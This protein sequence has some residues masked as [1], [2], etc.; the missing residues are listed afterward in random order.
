MNYLLARKANS[1]L[2]DKEFQG[3]NNR[4]LS[5][6]EQI[7]QVK[8]ITLFE[9]SNYQID[10]HNFVSSIQLRGGGCFGST[11]N[12]S[13]FKSN[14]QQIDY[15]FL[16][17]LSTFA[18]VISEKSLSFQ[19]KLYQDE[20]LAAFQWFQNN[21]EQF[22][23]LCND[24]TE[25]TKNYQL[26][27]KIT[28]Q[29]M[30]QLIIYIKVSG[31]LFKQLL[32]IC[33]DFWKI[34]FSHQ[35]QN[36]DRYMQDEM[37]KSFLEIIEEVDSQ[38]SVE[39][40][41]IWI[42][43]A[44]FELQLIKICV[45]HCRT[46]SEKGKELVISI[47]SGLF[48]SI[49]QLKP[50]EELID[51]LIEGGK[52]LLLNFYDKQIQNPLQVYEI[53][54]YFEN[55]KWSIVFQLKLGYSIQN[56][57]KQIQDGYT[58][59]IKLSKDW[60]V[61][62]FW[63]NLISDIMCYRPIFLKTEIQQLQQSQTVDEETW[64]QLIIKLPYNKFAGKLKL[65]S[66][67]NFTLKQYTTLKLFQEY[68]IQNQC[69]IQLLPNYINF[70]FNAQERKQFQDEELFIQ[71][72]TN[73]SNL[74]ILKALMKQLRY[75]NDQVTSNFVIAKEKV[76]QH[77]T[78]LGSE[79]HIQ[80]KI[81]CQ[82]L[83]FLMKQIKQS[84][85][86]LLYLINEINLFVNKELQINLIIQTIFQEQFKILE[87]SKKIKEQ[88]LKD[89]Q[90]IENKYASEFLG[91]FQN[92]SQFW[93]QIAQYTSFSHIEL[94]EGN[95]ELEKS[96]QQQLDSNVKYFTNI[97]NFLDKFQL[98]ISNVKT[99]FL[100][101]LEQQKLK[102]LMKDSISQRK[103]LDIMIKLFNPKLTLK[104]INESIQYYQ[105]LLQEE[106]QIENVKDVRK[107]LIVIQSN[108]NIY[109]GLQMI[110]KQHQKKLL[111]IQKQFQGAFEKISVDHIK[112]Q[113]NYEI[114][115]KFHRTAFILEMGDQ[116]QLLFKKYQNQELTEEQLT[117]FNV[118]SNKIS[119]EIN[120]IK[121]M[122]W[123][124]QIKSHHILLLS[125]IKL[126]L[127]LLSFVQQDR[128]II[129]M[130]ISKLLDGYLKEIN[131]ED[132]PKEHLPLTKNIKQSST[133]D[134]FLILK[135]KDFFDCE[136]PLNIL[137]KLITK[138]KKIK[139]IFRQNHLN[140]ASQNL[141][142]NFDLLNK[143]K[144]T[145][146]LSLK[147]AITDLQQQTLVFCQMIDKHE[148]IT[149]V[150]EFIE[151][152]QN[153]PN[154]DQISALLHI[155]N[156]D[157]LN[158]Q[159][160]RME[161]GVGKV[162]IIQTMIA[163]L[164]K[165]MKIVQE[166]NIFDTISD[167]SY[168]VREL[169][170]FNLIKIQ[171]IIQEQPI[172]EFCENLLK[173]I[174]IIE[175]N[176]NVR[177]LLKNEEMIKM[178]KKLFSQDL[179]NF[180]L[181][182]KKE[183]QTKFKQIE[184]LET[185][186]LLSGNQ[187][188]IKKS[189]QE[190]Y[191]EFEIYLD[192][193]TDMSQ[194]LDISLVFLREISKDLKNIKSSIDQIFL[195]VKG[196]ED[197][198][199]R[200]RGKNFMELL[201]IRKQKVLYQKLENEQDQIH[202]EIKTQE[203]DPISGNKK[204]NKSGEFE[205]FLMKL[206]F[207]NYDGE[208]NEFLWSEY[209]SLKDVML[210][211]GKAGS[212]KSR[213]SRNIEEFI[214]ICDSI[215]P[216]WIPIYMSLPQLKDPNHNLIEQAL[217]SENYNFDNIQIRE[218]KDAVINGTL[219]IVIILESYDEMKYEY[220]GTN[221]YN[222]NRIANDL[223]LQGQDQKVKFIITTREEILNT[224]GYQ[225]WF[226]GSSLQNLKEI[227]ILPFRQEQ[228]SQYLNIYAEISIKRTIKRFYEFLK[229]LK[230]QKFQLEEF[231]LIWSQIESTINSIILQRRKSDMLFL[232]SDIERIIKAI[233]NVQFFSF[234]QSNQ[235][236]S[237]KKE[238][239][240]LW[241]EQK[242]QSVVKNVNITHLL[243]TPFMME[244]IVYVLPKMSSL[245]SKANRIREL[246]KKNYMI[247]K[248]EANNS[249]VQME[250][251]QKYSNNSINFEA[252]NYRKS[253]MMKEIEI[254][255]Q[256][257][258]ILEDL[259]NSNFFESFSIAD[260]L[261]C[262][263][264]TT[265]F[266]NR[267][268][269]VKFDANYVVSAFKLQQYT[270]FDFYEIFVNFYHNQQLQKLKDLGISVKEESMLQDLNDF[271][272]FL[273]IDMSLRQLTQVNYKQKRKLY[274]SSVKE[275][276][277][278]EVSWDDSYF[279]ENQDDFEYK[280]LL[281]KCM[282]INSKGSLYAFNHKSIQEFFVANYIINLIETIFSQGNGEA[283]QKFLKQ[284][285]FCK[286][287]FNLSLEHYSG[288][289][290][291]LK[292][293]I[294]QI[295]DIKNKLIQLTLLSRKNPENTLIRSA[296]NSIYILC[297]LREHFENI[298]LSDLF[299]YYTKLDGMSFYKCNL[300]NSSFN[301]VSIDSCNFNCSTIENAKWENLICKEK[302][303]IIAHP[304]SIKYV[305]FSDNGKFLISGSE[306][307]VIIKQE[308]LADS[309]PKRTIL[310]NTD[311]DKL[312]TISIGKNLLA[313]LSN[314]FLYIFSL[315]DLKELQSYLATSIYF[316]DADI[317]RFSPNDKYL[318]VTLRKGITL[319][320]LVE[321]L[322]QQQE[323]Q[324]KYLS[325]I[326][327][328]IIYHIAI[329]P[330]YQLLATG[331]YRVKIWN[332]SNFSDVQ[333]ILELPGET[334]KINA[335][336]FSKD[337]QVLAAAIGNK[338]EFW[339]IQ[340]LNQ[341]FLKYKFD[342]LVELEQIS[343]SNNGK[344]F[345]FRSKQVLKLYE[346]Q[347]LP[348]Q[349][350]FFRINSELPVDLIEISS[351]CQILAMSHIYNSQN[352]SPKITIWNVKNLHQM[353]MISV[354]KEQSKNISAL[355]IRNDNL[356]LGSGSLDHSICL[357]DLLKLVL[358]VKLTSHQD[359]ILDLAFSSNKQQM[360][361]CSVDATIIVW[362]TTNL[363]KPQ[364]KMTQ[365]QQ[366]GVKKVLYC[367]N[368]P[369]LV[370]M[371][372]QTD[373]EIKL[374]NSAEFKLIS[375]NTIQA[376]FIDINFSEDGENMISLNQDKILRIWKINE[377]GF[378]IYKQIKIDGEKNVNQAY[379]FD[380]QSIIARFG[381]SVYHLYIKDQEIQKK[382]KYGFSRKLNCIQVSQNK[383]IIVMKDDGNR[384]QNNIEI[385]VIENHNRQNN[386]QVEDEIN[387]FQFSND[388]SLL[389]VATEKG[390]F[391]KD[392]I[393]NQILQNFQQN[394]CCKLI[395]FIGKEQLAIMLNQ[396]LVLYDIQD[397]N[398]SKII[399]IIQLYDTP[400]KMIFLEQRQEIC[401]CSKTSVVLIS[402]LEVQQ[403]KLIQ[404][405]EDIQ[406]MAVI[407]D[408][409]Q[410]FMGIGKRYKMQFMSLSNA[411]KIEKTSNLYKNNQNKPHIYTNFSQDCNIF[412]ILT[413]ELLYLQLDISSNQ[414]LKKVSFQPYNNPCALNNQETLIIVN[415][416]GINQKNLFLIDLETQKTVNCFDDIDERKSRCLTIVFSQDGQ[417]FLTS[418][419]NLTIKFWD[420]KS[421]KLLS[422]FKT[423]T[424]S[425][426]LLTISIKGI[427]AQTSD[428]IIKLWDL[429]ALKQQQQE[430]DGHNSSVSEIC[431]S[432]DG[433]Q[434]VTGSEEE[435]IRWDFI[436]LKQLDI[437][438][439][440]K[441]PISKF[442]FSPNSQYF[443]ALFEKSIHIWK[444]ITRYII[445]FHKTY[446]CSLQEQ[447]LGVSQN[448]VIYKNGE[449]KIFIMNF[450]QISKQIQI[451]L[452]SDLRNQTRKIILSPN[453]LIKT[454]P[455][456]ILRINNKLELKKE[457]I[458]GISASQI[459][460]IAYCANTQRFAFE[461]ED[462]SIIIWSIE[463]KQ[464]LGILNSNENKNTQ[465]VCM[466]FSGNSK[467]LF[468]YHDDKKIRLWN[469]TDKYELIQIQ[470][471]KNDMYLVY[472][473]NLQLHSSKDEEYILIWCETQP[474]GDFQMGQICFQIG[475]VVRKLDELS[476]EW[477]K[478]F[479]AAFNLSNNV[480][481]L[482]TESI[483]KLYDISQEEIRIIANLENN[484]LDD[485]LCQSNLMFSS[486]GKILLS[487]GTDFTVRLCDISDQSSIIVK[488]NMKKPIQAVAVQFLNSE[489]IR[490]Y[491]ESGIIIDQNISEY[492]EIGVIK[493]EQ[494]YDFKTA[495]QQ[496]GISK[497]SGKINN[498]TLE[499][500]DSQ[501][502]QLQF[503]LNKFSSKISAI[504]FTPSQEQFI[505]GMEDGSIL[506]YKIDQQTIKIYDIPTCYHIFAKNPLLS[507]QNCN[508]R[509]STF[510][511]I[512]NE[513]FEKVLCE[514]GAIK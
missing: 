387:D 503:T 294:I 486:D 432:P 93:L 427:L 72:L 165:D 9:I 77:D 284:C 134:E 308:M 51:S 449:S 430:M 234:I 420:T 447:K 472:S 126:Q 471:L 440:G 489:T 164:Q 412:S 435:I 254:T 264:N 113:E 347:K 81:F 224:I 123:P 124:D 277:N 441:S 322:L 94:I 281:R 65:F 494:Q 168:K 442:C 152:S 275:E 132:K 332:S 144:D 5:I 249:Q 418:Y 431:I 349:Q 30:R 414:I 309:E 223:N 292:P 269:N 474:W 360:A 495:K 166:E 310:T 112:T 150:Y 82:E 461:D 49:S 229:Q 497:Y 348:D 75:Q 350:D 400:E 6:T 177:S 120:K 423:D 46:N 413:S 205:T 513:N 212:G 478:K 320:F 251:Y 389:A 407:F 245:F 300:S 63:V 7:Q 287:E 221:L 253:R 334:M 105:K 149:F 64:N 262:V 297:S 304:S 439:K 87:D 386:V 378:E 259:D 256:F 357:W 54:L 344:L 266:S 114:D 488:V 396:Q 318:A 62:Y 188:E 483:L 45:S 8:N 260:S 510:K 401:I 458:A 107:I 286:N 355:K 40:V 70:N 140:A 313:C 341:V 358:I 361:S 27:E 84:S 127:E 246:L 374:W 500:F 338:L 36:E 12:R 367:P 492:L 346:V 215:S 170:V 66:N 169:V 395:C 265:I 194:R 137:E 133:D 68:L 116:L 108:I 43:G 406:P 329:S 230:G 512:E 130:E 138:T 509:Q 78:L 156:F 330:N 28:E 327:N 382:H 268:F 278:V 228:S 501:T 372:G 411:I 321:N 236:L 41:N 211:K 317:I 147:Q 129:Q 402:L 173:Q 502:S 456:E 428:N 244:I 155:F 240:Q 270:A 312:R 289:L 3:Q 336:A 419:S 480:I 394:C 468:S 305:T 409:E 261:E 504:Q 352:D 14:L 383:K 13:D 61:H 225:T 416:P 185:Q 408:S 227:E 507:A 99:K 220:I 174:W 452:Q 16:A 487:L 475:T 203:Y 316:K 433:L 201:N 135:L 476:G 405:D 91:N 448:H 282:L 184:Q 377:Q 464:Q 237:L 459:T 79:K 399:S 100:K 10:Y 88:I 180:S 71:S 217:E 257:T 141:Q 345:A 143:L 434:M 89:I 379:F 199:R 252:E 235:M 111:S 443:V 303:S 370:S 248:K 1:I 104:L 103:L 498:R 279:D 67:N 242:F 314:K 359:K 183:M 371:Q 60:R 426:Q 351:D 34:I 131:S 445:E 153:Q 465:L 69:D 438:I 198:I 404:F 384:N 271:S 214:W 117:D 142:N 182:I 241:G 291:L 119:K 368:R 296:S 238:L 178:Q 499:I 57:I 115:I 145:Q 290:E 213:A 463:K 295:E 388:A 280:S 276:R 189:L 160:Q 148:Q 196:V 288:T 325:Q 58:K 159:D 102:G 353:K 176:P 15:R 232:M 38:I 421:C 187:D 208:V 53:Y 493:D 397:I 110:F 83:R 26:I 85:L 462:Q 192:N 219:K 25:N 298:D 195:S 4:N 32:Q 101:I 362:D 283:N 373:N 422:T 19:D 20:V 496:I 285:S 190:Q 470:N 258:Q 59:Y 444:F 436:A 333:Q 21:R 44:K 340:N 331:D 139:S 267:I 151:K 424:N 451:Q 455:L 365:Q 106:I 469:I 511:T 505:L 167:Q 354:L 209:E 231:K 417:N 37:Q 56:I 23:I 364:I 136:E 375:T 50:S 491:S 477:T 29:L 307:G 403:I 218:F 342:S 508:I 96:L 216:N 363:D 86:L 31:F 484:P 328:H 450:E 479:S 95:I 415:S 97:N 323:Q 482:Q 191:D 369:L 210:I 454:N 343:Y 315:S 425:I 326:N 33:N 243:S 11:P 121:F 207:D 255:Q 239:L 337:N 162:D 125:E 274:I 197:D 24:Q 306:T 161:H 118:I 250:I 128:N 376:Q 410:K 109:K 272:T 172:Q 175:K 466:I 193:I 122:D 467:I 324:L 74:E 506:L 293:K 17:Q 481:A 73:Q 202:I 92:V 35:L 390:A 437:L 311:N 171:S 154:L 392:I 206:Q 335:I 52:F 514:K 200:L 356:V 273:A 48:Q 204:K 22:H 460:K 181:K 80:F 263:N 302:P 47:V 391:I 90:E 381:S 453:L 158:F 485:L 473:V 339:N 233:Q 222:R 226:Y 76:S 398:S 39:A 42:N 385:I 247:L 380:S 429:N 393:T 157:T 163:E 490:I 55:L 299:I 98:Q 366:L 2:D 446:W 146:T 457:Q 186:V 179:Q 18:N 301:N 319:F